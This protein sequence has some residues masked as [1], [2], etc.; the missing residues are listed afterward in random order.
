LASFD[1]LCDVQILLGFATVLPLLQSIHN[2]IKFNQLKEIFTCGYVP[3]PKVCQGKIYVLYMD[4]DIEF[5]FDAFDGYK[6][7]LDVKYESIVMHWVIDLN[8]G[9]EHLTYLV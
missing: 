7:L 3:T 9:V 4:V 6:S 1:L 2:L 5:K 8:T